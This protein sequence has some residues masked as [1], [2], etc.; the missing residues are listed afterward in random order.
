MN[1]LVDVSHF[2]RAAK[3]LTSY[4]KYWA[5]RFGTAKFLPMSRTEMDKLGWDSCDV[6]LVTG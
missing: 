1:A 3:P 2:P 4:R 5:A 6:I